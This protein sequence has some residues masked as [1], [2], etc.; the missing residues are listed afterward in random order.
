M[1]ALVLIFSIAFIGLA[2]IVALLVSVVS[3]VTGA[4]VEDEY[5]N[6]YPDNEI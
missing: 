1:K 3:S 2:V 6:H 4:F 5:D